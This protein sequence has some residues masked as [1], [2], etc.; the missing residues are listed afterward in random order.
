[1]MQGLLSLHVTT[2]LVVSFFDELAVELAVP[3]LTTAFV[4]CFACFTASH[5]L[6][7]AERRSCE[8]RQNKT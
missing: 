3:D 7:R 2:A 8:H 1:M 5:L 4:D 6:G